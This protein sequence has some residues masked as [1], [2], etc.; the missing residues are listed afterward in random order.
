M[1]HRKTDRM[2]ESKDQTAGDEHTYSLA[3][4]IIAYTPTAMVQILARNW[5]WIAMHVALSAVMIGIMRG[6]IYALWALV[7]A[8]ATDFVALAMISAF[9]VWAKAM[10]SPT[11]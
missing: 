5:P 3:G 10:A 6:F 7:M 2:D 9:A 8:S 11:E 1:P 4:F